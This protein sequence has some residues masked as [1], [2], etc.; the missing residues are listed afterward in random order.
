[1]VRLL[2]RAA[3]GI[4]GLILLAL[5]LFRFLLAYVLETWI[6]GRGP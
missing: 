5:V 4:T 2:L 1:M 3:L 6:D